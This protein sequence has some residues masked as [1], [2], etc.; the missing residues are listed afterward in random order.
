MTELNEEAVRRILAKLVDVFGKSHWSAQ[1][2]ALLDAKDAALADIM[3]AQKI[4]ANS[5]REKIAERDEAIAAK[6]RAEQERDAAREG[7]MI[8]APEGYVL[9]EQAVFTKMARAEQ[10]LAER[11]AAIVEVSARA[12][13]LCSSSDAA[14]LTEPLKPFLPAKPDP[15]VAAYVEHTDDCLTMEEAKTYVATL[16]AAIERAGGTI[17]FEGEGG[18]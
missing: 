16:R 7:K 5:I 15:L 3:E 4:R 13:A 11:D 18:G 9:V 17:S 8:Y 14:H 12:Y 2:L 6:D 1:A 10:A